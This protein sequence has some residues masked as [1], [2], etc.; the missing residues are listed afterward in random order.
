MRNSHL[1]KQL[2]QSNKIHIWEQINDIE[3]RI[4]SGEAWLQKIRIETVADQYFWPI[5]M[6]L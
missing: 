1:D 4:A 2:Q 3:V 5:L 6:I